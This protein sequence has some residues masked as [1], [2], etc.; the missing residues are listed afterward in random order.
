MLHCT[1][2]VLVLLSQSN[3]NETKRS[4]N[5]M[6]GAAV[7]DSLMSRRLRGLLCVLR[8]FVQGEQPVVMFRTEV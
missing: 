5:V 2:V 1:T 3:L 4:K 6:G 7:P 8:G